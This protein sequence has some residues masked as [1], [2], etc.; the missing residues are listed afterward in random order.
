MKKWNKIGFKESLSRNVVPKS[1]TV[2]PTIVITIE[3]AVLGHILI[4]KV[5][6]ISTVIASDCLAFHKLT[7]ILLSDVDVP[8]LNFK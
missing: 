1:L 8:T 6:Y 2:F 7:L 4:R 5:H 3:T